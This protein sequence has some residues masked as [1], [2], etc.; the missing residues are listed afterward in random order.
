MKRTLVA[1]LIIA[2]ISLPG[3]WFSQ[4]TIVQRWTTES[5]EI[6]PNDRAIVEEVDRT[7]ASWGKRGLLASA[8]GLSGEA[9]GVGAP[10]VS[11]FL[12]AFNIIPGIGTA[13]SLGLN[14]LSGILGIFDSS[15]RKATYAEGADRLQSAFNEYLKARQ[16]VAIENKLEIPSGKLTSEGRELFAALNRTIKDVNKALAGHLQPEIK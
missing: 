16:A 7:S 8:V 5:G 10:L 12:A 2:L 15:E 1:F 11:G 3:C 4:L 14:I 13:I 6:V 9:A